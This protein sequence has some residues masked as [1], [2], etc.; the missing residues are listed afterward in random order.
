MRNIA[1]FIKKQSYRLFNLKHDW[2][3][4]R[5]IL[6]QPIVDLKLLKHYLFT[7]G[8]F[9]YKMSQAQTCILKNIKRGEAKDLPD[10]II[11]GS[12]K[13][14]VIGRNTETQIESSSV[15]REHRKNFTT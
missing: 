9:N 10:I 2:K 5:S 11:T 8:R 14:K 4:F 12:E 13:K 3:S 15:S 6:I 1:D 7:F